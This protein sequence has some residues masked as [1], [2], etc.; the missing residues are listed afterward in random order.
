[1]NPWPT[2]RGF[3]NSSTIS[4]KFNRTDGLPLVSKPHVCITSHQIARF[5]Y[6]S[7]MIAARRASIRRRG[8]RSKVG[9]II[10]IWSNT[11]RSMEAISTAV[12]DLLRGIVIP[13]IADVTVH[14]PSSSMSRHVYPL[15]TSL[16][17]LI[18][19]L[20]RPMVKVTVIVDLE[21]Y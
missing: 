1:M 4:T 11:W 19:P 6:R 9:V 15:L 17:T 21:R 18:A 14:S 16:Q 10:H 12:H 20:P 7:Y 8:L 2:V 5:T 13:A 3:L